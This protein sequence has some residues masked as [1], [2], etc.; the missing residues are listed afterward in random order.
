MTKITMTVFSAF[1]LMAGVMAIVTPENLQ[2]KEPVKLIFDTD[3]G[4]DIDDTMAIAVIHALQ[5]RG[6]CELL[7]V[8]ITKDNQYAAPMVSILNEFYGRPDIPVGIV[9][10]GVTKEDGLYLGKMC[11]LK[12]EEGKPVFSPK[13][14]PEMYAGLPDA[15]TVLRK[16]LAAQPDRSVVMVQVGFSTNLLRLLESKADE[17][18]PLDGTALVK[19]KVKLLSTMAGAF[20]ERLK[21][22]AEYNIACDIPSARK[23]F[24]LWPTPIVFSGYEIGE[25]INYPA[26]SMQDDFGYTPHHPVQTAYGFYRGL[27]N[28]QATFDL[29]SALYAVRPDRGYFGLSE[30]GDV[31]F[32]EKAI[33][34]FS[35]NPNGKSRYMTVTPEQ[36]AQVREALCGFSSEPPKK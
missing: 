13:I 3:I 16:T 35:P 28:D 27:E 32:D 24:E 1:L 30:P 25:T 11:H 22:H 2:A 33:T 29:T 20:V 8:T 12:N 6:E 23:M 36:I 18:S 14:T 10:N 15:T 26:K 21:T 19:Q 31:S 34:H 7:A 4:N 9:K 17:I 5:N